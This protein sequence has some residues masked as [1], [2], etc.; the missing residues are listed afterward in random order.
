MS[1]G[2]A[3]RFASG[4]LPVLRLHYSADPAKR[5][6]TP[7]GEQWLQQALAGYPGGRE[8]P[9]WRKEMEIDY[10]ALS[11][12]KLFPDWAAWVEAGAIVQPPPAESTLVGARFYGSY[13]HGW[14]RPA[15]YLVHAIL[16]TGEKWTLW[17]LSAARAPIPPLA[18][19]IGGES[20]PLPDGRR[21]PG[22]PY[23][24]REVWRRADPE[25]WAED[26]QG[27][28]IFRSV[29]ALFRRAGLVF[30]PGERGGDL[31]VAEWLLGVEWRDPTAPTYRIS[32]ACPQLIRELGSLRHQEWSPTVAQR[33]AAPEALVDK[34]CDAWDALKYFLQAFP[35]GPLA[36]KPTLVPQTFQWWRTQAQRAA[37][38]QAVQT[39]QRAQV[40]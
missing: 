34:D 6:G 17:E 40:R 5:P 26:Q 38:G 22:N 35:P 23:A 9:R 14:R 19:A 37:R 4:S 27:D 16:P 39:Y 12:T 30:T 11:G 31:T 18:R 32:T 3:T 21:L 24:G 36:A 8:S 20:A 1:Q 10:G 33:R 29:A 15:V 25:I 7:E 13:D 28:A 2:I